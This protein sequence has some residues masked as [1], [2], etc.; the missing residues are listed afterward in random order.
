MSDE[1][2]QALLQ[3]LQRM[4]DLPASDQLRMQYDQDRHILAL[5]RMMIVDMA[6]R[7][8][9]ESNEAY[10]ENLQV[11]TSRFSG[12]LPSDPFTDK[13]FI[14]RRAKDQF[15]LYSTGPNMTDGGGEFGPWH[16]VAAGQADLCLDAFDYSR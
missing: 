8:W 2:Q 16:R 6:L 9:R 1:Q 5:S 11:L 12:T 10:P 15:L 4:A 14:Y 7:D 3:V 13:P